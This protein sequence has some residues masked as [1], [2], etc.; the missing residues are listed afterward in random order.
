MFKRAFASGVARGVKKHVKRNF[1]RKV[2]SEINPSFVDQ[3]NYG[4]LSRRIFDIDG[5]FQPWTVKKIFMGKK[6]CNLSTCTSI[7]ICWEC[8]TKLQQAYINLIKKIYGLC[9]ECVEKLDLDYFRDYDTA[10]DLISI[11]EI[12]KNV[13]IDKI[14]SKSCCSQFRQDLFKND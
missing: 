5:G 13:E 7:E 1:N 10:F 3:L 4:C 14:C 8:R 11:Q 6:N 2:Y 9:D 12:S